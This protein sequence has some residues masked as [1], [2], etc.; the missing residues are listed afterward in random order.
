MAGL[1]AMAWTGLQAAP[2]SPFNV[3][4]GPHRR[5]TWVQGELTEFKAVKNALG[6]TVNDVVL[7]VVA[8]GLG[9]YMRPHG[10][11]TEDVVLRA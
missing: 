2:P 3:R 5:F 9:R 11:S 10:Y 7:A 8:G 6:G 4:I 1:G